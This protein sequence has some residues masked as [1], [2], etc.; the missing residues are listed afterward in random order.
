[1]V[2]DKRQEMATIVTKNSLL[3]KK[4]SV[5]TVGLKVIQGIIGQVASGAVAAE[6]GFPIG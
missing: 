5:A 6:I 1:M 3:V 4:E 2:L